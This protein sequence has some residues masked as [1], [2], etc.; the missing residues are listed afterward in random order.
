MKIRLTPM[1]VFLVV[2]ALVLALAAC[3]P[4]TVQVNNCGA[5]CEQ[6]NQQVTG[7]GDGSFNE[8]TNNGNQFEAGRD[9]NGVL[10]PTPVPLDP[11]GS[12]GASLPP[13]CS[14]LIGL[15]ALAVV[16]IAL[17]RSGLGGSVRRLRADAAKVDTS[18]NG[19]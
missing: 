19:S 13:F 3:G 10:M 17:I 9:V 2:V 16:A 18:G 5:G 1:K 14:L 7:G 12:S 15:G 11:P 8:A 4:S 6:K